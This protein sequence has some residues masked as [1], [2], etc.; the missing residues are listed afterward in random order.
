MDY[1]AYTAKELAMDEHFQRWVLH[2]ESE[3]LHTFWNAWLKAHPEKQDTVREARQW[4]E[5]IRFNMYTLPDTDKSQMLENVFTASTTHYT[6]HR[7]YL[8]WHT[9]RLAA[10]V[11][12][13]LLIALAGWILQQTY[14]TDKVYTTAFGEQ[15][16]ILLPDGSTVMLNANSTLTLSKNWQMPGDREVWL[17]G[18][19]FFSVVHT[20]DHRKFKV[21]TSNGLHIEVLG[22]EFNVAQRLHTTKVVLSSGKVKL[23]LPPAVARES[24]LMK[25]G[26]LVEYT[27]HHFDKRLVDPAIYTAWTHDKLVLNHTSL[28]EITQML[29]DNYGLQIKVSHKG[30][31]EQTV[32]GSMPLGDVDVLLTQIG[33]TFRISVVRNGQTVHMSEKTD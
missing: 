9:Y 27:Q 32:S 33:K 13:F 19:G 20:A 15:Q 28:K 29:Q 26:E 16:T 24:I 10:V 18:E 2:P 21:H 1:T 7:H 17:K 11:A 30:L 4:L 6:R 5:Q 8:Q 3:E 25:P 12:G 14:F 22:T 31:L 23:N